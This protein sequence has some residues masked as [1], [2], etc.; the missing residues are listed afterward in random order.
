MR[1]LMTAGAISLLALTAGCGQQVSETSQSDG[2]AESVERATGY[3]VTIHRDEWGVPH[4][5]GETD[6]DTAY[7]MGWAQAE[8]N[9]P[10]FERNMVRAAGRAAEYLGEEYL[11]EDWMNRSLRIETHSRNEHETSSSAVSALVEAYVQAFNDYAAA[12]PDDVSLPMT[13]EPWHVHAYIRFIYYQRGFAYFAGLSGDDMM[14]GMEWL[15]A[16]PVSTDR[17]PEQREEGEGSNSWAVS[18]HRTEN[19]NALLF[20][21][22]HLPWFG[23]SQVYESHVMSDEGWNFTGY[24]RFGFPVPYIGFGEQLGWAS[25]DNYAD[26]ADAYRLSLTEDGDHYQFGAQQRPLTRWSETVLVKGEDGSLAERELHFAES[27]HGPILGYQDGAP[28]AIRLSK[29]E[30][31]GWLAQWYAMSK[32]SDLDSF[33]DAVYEL[34]ML[35]GNY[36]YADQEGNIFYVYNAAV[37]IRS[38]GHDWSGIVDGS[39]PSTD[40]LGYHPMEELPQV[41][42]PPGGDVQNSNGTPFLSTSDGTGNPD[43]DNYPSYMV[44]EI[45]SAPPDGDIPRHRRS[46]DI[47]GS[48]DTFT[49]EDFSELAFDTYVDQAQYDLPILFEAYDGIPDPTPRMMEAITLLRE[50]DLRAE[51]ETP[52]MTLYATWGEFWRSEGMTSE[53]AVSAFDQ[54]IDWMMDNHGQIDVAWGE[55]NRVQR[56]TGVGDPEFSSDIPSYPL[57]GGHSWTGTMMTNWARVGGR[58]DGVGYPTGGHSYV[59]VIE[60]GERVR[61]GSLQ[62]MGASSRPDSPHY[63]DQAQLLSESR[64]KTA[65]LYRDEVLENAVRSYVPGE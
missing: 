52:A 7:G 35:F 30:E 17:E 28:V 64:F 63:F 36:L 29:L 10:Q 55:V 61:A 48:Q 65:W 3:N 38:E 51:I 8:D 25:T 13:F 34:D 58:V 33:T 60:F 26:Q 18:P 57:S 1:S 4:I 31:P 50:W 9:F 47:M 14:A 16:E 49:F 40:W 44:G 6:A 24:A 46:R 11:R 21:N 19:G 43:P 37:P 39:N 59:A 15:N 22:P 5:I 12:H 56:P 20:I 53:T 2:M 54:A 32:A 45:R 41:F 23:A 42:N 62:A 27:H